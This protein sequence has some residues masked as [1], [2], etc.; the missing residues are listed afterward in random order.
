M[1]VGLL[2]HSVGQLV[3]RKVTRVWDKRMARLKY[4]KH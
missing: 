4:D 1:P 2:S 3:V